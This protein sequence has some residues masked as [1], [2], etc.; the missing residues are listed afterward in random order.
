[1]LNVLFG[2]H[3]TGY[4]L[5]LD[6]PEKN[7]TKQKYYFEFLCIHHLRYLIARIFKFMSHMVLPLY[8]YTAKFTSTMGYMHPG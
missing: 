2:K 6:L 7:K 8:V 5:T 3:F 1:M 4:N